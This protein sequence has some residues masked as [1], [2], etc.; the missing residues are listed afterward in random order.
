MIIVEQRSHFF[1]NFSSPKTN[2]M[3][4]YLYRIF[5]E[6]HLII[7][8]CKGPYTI[9]DLKQAANETARDPA[10]NPSMNVLNDF[11]QMDLDMVE[12]EMEAFERYLESQKN[13]I[14]IRKSAFL[15]EN[16][17]QTVFSIML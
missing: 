12:S 15:T 11:R 4:K 17:K 2:S 3:K 16:P 6:T 14:G 10:Y 7:K 5:P 1:Y 9:E 13:M 8:Y